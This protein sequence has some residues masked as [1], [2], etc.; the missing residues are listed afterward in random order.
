M[1]QA[2]RLLVVE[3]DVVVQSFVRVAAEELGLRC[4]CAR[5]EDEFREAFDAA[6]ADALVLDLQLACGDAIEVLRHLAAKR[7]RLPILLASGHDARTLAAAAREGAE[8]GLAIAGTLAKPFDRATLDAA[9]RA[10]LPSAARLDPN[11]VARAVARGEV[12][13][14]F[15]PRVDLRQGRVL[16]VRAHA[17]AL[18]DDARATHAEIVEAAESLELGR[19]LSEHV[20]RRSLAFAGHWRRR[21]LDLGVCV[22]VGAADL[23]DA[24]FADRA[25]DALGDHA[26]PGQRL[27]LVARPADLLRRAGEVCQTLTRLR[28]QGVRCDLD[29]LDG[30]GASLAHLWRL[31]LDGVM[32]DG[33]LVAG[34]RGLRE[35]REVLQALLALCRRLGLST[36]AR[37]LPDRESVEWARLCGVDQAQGRPLSARLAPDLVPDWVRVQ[38]ELPARSAV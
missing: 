9:L 25:L 6:G 14:E 27:R 36:C 15:E 28:I 10:L 38:G 32:I 22:E 26:V 11:L 24:R 5:G 4:A 33:A 13:I 35:A 29:D 21:G 18:G 2:P 1:S 8:L 7:A 17:A 37:D 3:D 12:E 16:D 19:H 30:V 31:P 20:L 34:A 23:A